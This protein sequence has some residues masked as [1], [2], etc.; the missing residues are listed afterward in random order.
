MTL[1]SF[2]G[3][4]VGT[5]TL[6]AG[7]VLLAISPILGLGERSSD[8]LNNAWAVFGAFAIGIFVLLRRGRP[9]LALLT[10]SVLIMPAMLIF[11]LFWLH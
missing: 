5:L 8:F 9:F 1:R 10:F 6:I 4:L 3:F 2:V 11:L 7:L